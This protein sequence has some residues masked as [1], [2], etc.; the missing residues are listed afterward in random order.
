[1]KRSSEFEP[2]DM[3]T[4]GDLAMTKVSNEGKPNSE[5]VQ[6]FEIWKDADGNQY[7]PTLRFHL[8]LTEPNFNKFT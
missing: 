6:A 1:M 5:G 7:E 2:G 4:W 8:G 3:V